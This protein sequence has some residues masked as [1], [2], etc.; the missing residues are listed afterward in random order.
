M[1][2]AA[3]WGLAIGALSA[4][5][6]CQTGPLFRADT[7]L[8]LVPVTVTDSANRYVLGLPKESFHLYE[9]GVE[10]KVSSFSTEDAP[11]SV[12][13]IV[14]V[15]GSMGLKLRL[16]S[17]AVNDFLKTMNSADEAF[18]TEFSDQAEIVQPFT[19][20]MGLIG[21][22][23]ETLSSGGLTAMLDAIHIS[24]D[25]MKKAGNPRKALIVI[26]DGGDNHS[27]YNSG[28]IEQLVREADTQIFAMGVFEAA[29]PFG[30]T[31]AELDGPRL[32]SE[33]ADQTGGR[34]LA[35]TSDR[36]LPAIASRIGVELRNQYVLAYRPTNDQHDGKYRKLE[37]KID[38]PAGLPMLKARWRAGYYAPS[39]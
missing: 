27:R 7:T 14:D 10:Q 26:S 4:C 36:E 15:S 3:H 20:D 37:V 34:A 29:G 9:D 16:S 39:E 24:L 30:L 25:E 12:G 2:R 31:I 21:K 6:F 17:T 33:L 8:V 28:Q 18:L 38:R 19:H 11:L 5:A 22:R 23:M 35:A 1:H 13:L 32:L